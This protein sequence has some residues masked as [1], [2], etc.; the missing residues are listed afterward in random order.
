MAAQLICPKHSSPCPQ[1]DL[2][3]T[4]C[5][6]GG[7]TCAR[8]TAARDP[9]DVG[10]PVMQS[11]VH[12]KPLSESAQDTSSDVMTS[13]GGLALQAT[14]KTHHSRGLPSTNTIWKGPC[15]RSKLDSARKI[16][17]SWI[18]QQHAEWQRSAGDAKSKQVMPKPALTA[19]QGR[20]WCRRRPATPKGGVVRMDGSLGHKACVC[21][22]EA[23]EA[24]D[25]FRLHF[26]KRSPQQVVQGGVVT[27]G[28]DRGPAAGR[29]GVRA[30]V[31]VKLLLSL[32]RHG[33]VVE[34]D[35]RRI[36]Q[37]LPR[38][39]HKALESAGFACRKCVNE[40]LTSFDVFFGRQRQGM[41]SICRA[42]GF[43][44]L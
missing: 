5:H 44:R 22:W 31:L 1:R 43:G 40:N 7:K 20:I 34:G 9:S 19:R 41:V 38:V 3:V 6:C 24:G 37:P 33:I 4:A 29:R 2:G 12:G 42:L 8:H 27:R 23:R 21:V 36:Q 32:Q 15:C 39:Q 26:R 25:V 18:L 17:S 35:G 11:A 10:V 30:V 16:G 14:R 13:H 28:E